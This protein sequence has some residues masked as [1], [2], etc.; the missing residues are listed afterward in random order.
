MG[1]RNKLPIY[2]FHLSRE[3]AE[4]NLLDFLRRIISDRFHGDIGGSFPRVTIDACRN[5]GEGD[6]LTAVFFSQI[7]TTLIARFQKLR[8][9]MSTVLINRTRSM[10]HKLCRKSE[11]WGDF[12]LA[13]FATVQGNA[14]FQELRTCRPV[15]RPVDTAAT[16]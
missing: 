16:Q 12:R 3:A 14:G 10:N 13:C 7:E 5:S 1:S 6:C 15:N 2:F 9:S 8:F 4:N 11:T